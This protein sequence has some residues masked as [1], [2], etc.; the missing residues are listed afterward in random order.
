MCQILFLKYDF[1]HHYHVPMYLSHVLCARL[2][3]SDSLQPYGLALQA[4]L[5]MGFSKQ[6]YWSGLPCPSP[7]DLPNLGIEPASLTSPAL[8][9]G[10]FTT[11][12]TW[13]GRGTRPSESPRWDFCWPMRERCS[14]CQWP[15]AGSQGSHTVTDVTRKPTWRAGERALNIA[16]GPPDPALSEAQATPRC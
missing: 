13:D 15:G 4:P 1:T 9:G 7:G 6:E 11:S 3:L 8:A 2:L 16:P 14:L 10:F 12:A 5:S